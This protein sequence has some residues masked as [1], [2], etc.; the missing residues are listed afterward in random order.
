MLDKYGKYDLRQ[1][2][3]NSSPD[4]I[5]GPLIKTLINSLTDNLETI[6]NYTK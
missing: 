6:S 3:T 4:T 1:N 5:P 2:D